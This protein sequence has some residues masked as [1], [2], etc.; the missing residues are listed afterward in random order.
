MILEKSI[1]IFAQKY[2]QSKFVILKQN[3]FKN[4]HY[5]VNF[6]VIVY[7]VILLY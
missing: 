3:I 6:I 1:N 2:Q 4:Q 5:N 7:D